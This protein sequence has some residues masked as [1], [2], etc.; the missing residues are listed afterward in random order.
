MLSPLAEVILSLTVSTYLIKI[1]VKRPMMMMIGGI[2]YVAVKWQVNK[3]VR[4]QLPAEA[5]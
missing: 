4:V 1:K 5:E 2:W 3:V